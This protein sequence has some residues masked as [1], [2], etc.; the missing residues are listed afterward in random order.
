MGEVAFV[1]S[2][3]DNGL[4]SSLDIMYIIGGSNRREELAVRSLQVSGL[5]RKSARDE[6]RF[7]DLGA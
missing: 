6:P 3:A 7:H 1:V 4:A 2:D 5:S